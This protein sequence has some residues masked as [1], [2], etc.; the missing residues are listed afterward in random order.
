M[1]EACPSLRKPSDEGIEYIVIPHQLTALCPTLMSVLSEADNAKHS[2]YRRETAL[3]TMMNLHKRIVQ[4]LDD[5]EDMVN[6]IC[7]SQ[8]AFE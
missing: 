4:S 3:Q 5:G 7:P 2:T 8:P 1:L 6:C